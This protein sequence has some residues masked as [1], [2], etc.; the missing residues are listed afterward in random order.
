MSDSVVA[1][2]ALVKHPNDEDTY[3]FVFDAVLPAGETIATVD[4]VAVDPGTTPPLGV[5]G[6]APNAAPFVDDDGKTVEIGH[7]VQASVTGGLAGT[8]YRLTVTVTLS[9]GATKAGVFPIYVR[10]GS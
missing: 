5:T 8:N 1:Q 10:D 9:G 6:A 3:G 4:S 7:A 2:P